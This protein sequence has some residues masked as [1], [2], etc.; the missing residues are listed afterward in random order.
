M[1]KTRKYVSA[2]RYVNSLA[3]LIG[4][5]PPCDNFFD[6]A[7]HLEAY[8]P[9]RWCGREDPARFKALCEKFERNKALVLDSWLGKE[10]AR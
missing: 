10:V 2:E 6:M 4:T 3:K 5:K 7:Y 1:N 9:A 8:N